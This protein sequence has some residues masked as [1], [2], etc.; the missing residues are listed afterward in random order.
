MKWDRT[1]SGLHLG[2]DGRGAV[3]CVEFAGFDHE[4]VAHVQG[5]TRKGRARTI[6]QCKEAAETWI[7]DVRAGER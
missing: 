3:A 2:S 1:A 7:A 6:R 4:W 5:L